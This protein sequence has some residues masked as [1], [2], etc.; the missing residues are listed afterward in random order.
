MKTQLLQDIDENG[1]A[2]ERRLPA[3]PAPGTPAASMAPDR[4]GAAPMQAQSLDLAPSVAAPDGGPSEPAQIATTAGWF[5]APVPA[6]GVHAWAPGADDPAGN[7]AGGVDL[8]KHSARSDTAPA[9]PSPAARDP[10]VWSARRAAGAEGEDDVAAAGSAVAAPA[11]PDLPWNPLPAE[12]YAAHAAQTLAPAD[13]R[14]V[15]DAASALPDPRTTAAPAGLDASGAAQE[16]ELSPQPVFSFDAAAADDGRSAIEAGPQPGADAAHSGSSAGSSAGAPLFTFE[17][18]PVPGAGFAAD[19]NFSAQTGGR[20]EPRF[21]VEPASAADAVAFAPRAM[22][23][24]MAATAAEAAAEAVADAA[25]DGA[26]QT[27]AAAPQSTSQSA[28]QA[29]DWL[30]ER[31]REDL[32]LR[33]EPAPGA[34]KRRVALWGV[35]GLVVALAGAGGAALYREHRTERA[36]SA[37]A[38]GAP[39]PAAVADPVPA[40]AAA[41]DPVPAANSPLGPMASTIAGRAPADAAADAPAAAPVAAPVAVTAPPA[42]AQAATTDTAVGPA[43][44]PAAPAAAGSGPAAANPVSAGTVAAG[45]AGAGVIAAV[46][47]DARVRAQPARLAT[48]PASA[49][50]G[51]A[52]KDDVAQRAHASPDR[53]ATSKP[54]SSSER[55]RA[56]EKEREHKREADA[57][58]QRETER[59]AERKQEAAR[60]AKRDSERVAERKRDR[61][62]AGAVQRKRVAQAESRTAPAVA[63]KQPAPRERREATLR[64]CRARG[65][66]ERQCIRRGCTT[67]R[68]GF[69]CKGA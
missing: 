50:P 15:H 29:A 28:P 54:A 66:N 65:Y 52:P 40:S 42:S 57:K 37:V 24:G 3:L 5:A 55:E 39:P 14:D 34:W 36:L 9:A 63:A 11:P 38:D 33:S 26:V 60:V 48:Q 67:T 49:A 69:A 43:A 12:G 17:P 59:A 8:S 61:E 13:V 22:A 32:A 51:K 27:A 31:L 68:F 47:A 1:S 18:D 21:G 16:R 25:A 20:P 64:E 35:A 19:G 58:R 56:R 7:G 10:R 44:A 30:A 46:A 62:P 6:A 4:A 45:V 2:A 41:A 53:E 23:G